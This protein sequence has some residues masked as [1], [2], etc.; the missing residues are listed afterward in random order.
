MRI[1]ITRHGE[2]E[3]NI[4]GIIMGHLHGKLSKKGIEQAEKLAERLKNEKIDIIISSD[5][6]RSFDTAKQIAKFHDVPIK[7]VKDLREKYMGE[8]QGKKKSDLGFVSN[9]NLVNISSKD[10]ETLEQLF[11][12]ADK[13][14]KKILIDHPNKNIL[15]VAHNGIIKAMMSVMDKKS[16]KYMETLENTDNT[17]VTIFE[18]DKDGKLYMKLFNSTNHLN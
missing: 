11:E 1:I 18:T 9:T 3:E 7:F 14:I 13:F 2:T 6:K 15:L 5:L 10:G 4:N 16:P 17:S 12:R 8:W